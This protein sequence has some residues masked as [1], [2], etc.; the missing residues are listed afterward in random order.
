[1]KA[2]QDFKKKLFESHE[3][4]FDQETALYAAKKLNVDFNVVCLKEFLLGMDVELE[5]VDITFGNPILTAK[6][7]LAHLKELPD[8]YT[9]LAKMEKAGKSKK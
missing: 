3:L 5:H 4:K 1:M 7:A 2:L 8:Y 9:R 6:I